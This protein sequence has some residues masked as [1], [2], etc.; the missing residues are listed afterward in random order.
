LQQVERLEVFD[1]SAVEWAGD[2]EVVQYRG[3][4]LP[5]VRLRQTEAA[6]GPLLHVVVCSEHGRNVGVVVERILD[7][8]EE[9]GAPAAG[10]GNLARAAVVQQRVT[11]LL[12]LAAVL[13]GVPG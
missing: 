9:E 8:V 11:D 5:L 6:N 10:Q 3:S 2:D 12:G 13:D 1:P 4:L 7:A